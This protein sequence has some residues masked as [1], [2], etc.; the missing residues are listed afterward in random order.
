[1]TEDNEI[2]RF[3]EIDIPVY[4]IDLIGDSWAVDE[5]KDLEVVKNRMIG[6]E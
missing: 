1:M 5:F 4:C 6:K 2:I 3:L